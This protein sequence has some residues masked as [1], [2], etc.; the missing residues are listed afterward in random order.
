MIKRGRLTCL[1]GERRKP[2][3]QGQP[4]FI[5]I[6]SVHQGDQDGMKGVY[7]LNAVDEITQFEIVA[8]VDKNIRALIDP[9]F[10]ADAYRLS[11][12]HPELSFR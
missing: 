8:S 5:R 10:R 1:I 7:Q 12:D 3:P 4:G 6:D 2:N 11:F 9:G